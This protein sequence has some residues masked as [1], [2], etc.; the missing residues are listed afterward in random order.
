MPQ[1]TAAGSQGENESG[2]E[3]MA[4]LLISTALEA[5][6]PSIVLKVIDDFPVVLFRLVLSIIS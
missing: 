3:R 4:M 6:P 2:S 1:R 5:S